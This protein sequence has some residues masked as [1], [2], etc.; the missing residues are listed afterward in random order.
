MTSQLRVFRRL[1]V[2]MFLAL[3]LV[4]GEERRF[5]E[6]MI[7]ALPSGAYFLNAESVDGEEMIIRFVALAETDIPTVD[8]LR[9]LVTDSVPPRV[10]ERLL[11]FAVRGA[12]PRAPPGLSSST[13]ESRPLMP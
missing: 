8:E 5:A 4:G 1:G 6:A 3:C 9:V 11:L 13:P 7:D 10:P 12:S 2:W